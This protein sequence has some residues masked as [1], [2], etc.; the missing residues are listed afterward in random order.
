MDES[1][2]P[3]PYSKVLKDISPEHNKITVTIDPHPFIELNYINVHPCKH[4]YMMKN[5]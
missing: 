2:Y 3:L 1:S 5:D 4:S